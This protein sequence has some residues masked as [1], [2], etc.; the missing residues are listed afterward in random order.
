MLELTD[1]AAEALARSASA[2]ARFDPDASLRVEPAGGGVAV[3]IV[4]GPQPGDDTI[5]RGDLHVHVD[6]SLAGT[7]DVVDPHETF[8]LI[9]P[10]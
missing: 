5:H 1:R 9:A 2:A 3:A 4:H 6:P 8:V 7:L 10:R